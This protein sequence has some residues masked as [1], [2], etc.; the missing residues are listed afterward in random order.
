VAPAP[1]TKIRMTWEKLYHTH[2]GGLS[3]AIG[4]VRIAPGLVWS[5]N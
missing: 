4:G 1:S 2:R 3:K 5:V